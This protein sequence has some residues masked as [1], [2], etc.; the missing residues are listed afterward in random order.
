MTIKEAY[1]KAELYLQKSNI[2]AAS[3]E[4]MCMIE[5]VF[6]TDRTGLIINGDKQADKESLALLDKMCRQ[7]QNHEP[8]Q[9]IL[10]KWDFM[11]LELFV[12]KGV[13]IPRDDTQVVVN[14]C[15]KFLEKSKSKK[16]LDLCSGSG[17]IAIALESIFPTAEITAVEKSDEA[18]F[19]LEKNIRHNNSKVKAVKGDI[20]CCHNDFADNEFDLIISNPPYIITDEIKTLQSEISFEPVLALDGGADGYDF[21]RAIITSWTRKLRRGGMLAFELGEGQ[22]DEVCRLMHE[23]GY[24][25]ISK[26]YDLGSIIRAINGTVR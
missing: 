10:G 7:R 17:A 1:K 23:S 4:A 15:V 14:S 24:E 22:F 25:N 21:Y 8:L 18:F 26:H 16:I 13:L 12:G 19:Y 20:F 5:S 6:G 9:Y 11:G 2:E 3:F